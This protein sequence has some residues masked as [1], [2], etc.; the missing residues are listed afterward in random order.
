MT[1]WPCQESRA[2][3]SLEVTLHHSVKCLLTHSG[4]MLV[5]GEAMQGRVEVRNTHLLEAAPADSCAAAPLA[6]GRCRG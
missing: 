5:G 1:L 6:W 3:Q 4:C 2:I